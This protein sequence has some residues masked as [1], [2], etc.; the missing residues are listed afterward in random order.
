MVSVIAFTKN[1]YFHVFTL[2]NCW[3]NGISPV[4]AMETDTKTDIETKIFDL[5]WIGWLSYLS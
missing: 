2:S 1:S 5:D 3:V 4:I